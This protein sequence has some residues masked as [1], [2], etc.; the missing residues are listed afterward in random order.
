MHDN[1]DYTER[2]SMI[3]HICDI[4]PKNCEYKV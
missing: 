3:V 1:F 2:T 4:S